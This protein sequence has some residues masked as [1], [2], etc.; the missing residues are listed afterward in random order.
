MILTI[1]FGFAQ[2]MPIQSQFS[3]NLYSINP[4]VAGALPYNPINMSYKQLWTGINETPQLAYISGNVAVKENLGIGA[5]VYSF[6]SGPFS[7]TGLEATYAYHLDLGENKLSFGL[8]AFMYQFNLNK[9][10]L[11]FEDTNE[12]VTFGASDMLIVP[13]AA[14]GI[15]FSGANYYAGLSAYQLFNRKIS[16]TVDDLEQRQVRHFNFNAGYI[17]PINA[18]YTIQGDVLLKYSAASDF[19]AEITAKCFM[20]KTLWVGASYQSSTAVSFLIGVGQERFAL[21]YAYDLPLS[22]IKAQTFGS[23]EIMLIYTLPEHKWQRRTFIPSGGGSQSK[24]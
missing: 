20:M 18:D 1:S 19:Q 10:D 7:K 9:A 3:N 14:F 6:K 8:S 16:M 11:K 12:P 22:D 23:H 15:F 24:L 4:A 21:G 17:Y 13:D 2:Q 5:K